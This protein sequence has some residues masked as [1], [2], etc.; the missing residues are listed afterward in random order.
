M[1]GDQ[2]PCLALNHGHEPKHCPEPEPKT[3]PGVCLTCRHAGDTTPTP[4]ELAE[5]IRNSSGLTFSQRAA[6][7]RLI[8]GSK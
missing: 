7:Y 8:E 6:V 1:K 2:C 3:G 4:D 5:A